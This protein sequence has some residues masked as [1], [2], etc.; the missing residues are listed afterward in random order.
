[1]KIFMENCIPFIHTVKAV[2]IFVVFTGSDIYAS[3]FKCKCFIFLVEL[4]DLFSLTLTLHR[5]LITTD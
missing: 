5:A 3:T 1:M 4:T 2:D